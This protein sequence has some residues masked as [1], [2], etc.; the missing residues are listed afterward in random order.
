MKRSLMLTSGLRLIELGT[1]N[2]RA[3]VLNCPGFLSNRNISDIENNLIQAKTTWKHQNAYAKMVMAGCLNQAKR[4]I[5]M[6]D[7]VL[8]DG[9]KPEILIQKT[10][11]TISQ[12]LRSDDCRRFLSNA[13]STEE[14]TRTDRDNF[15]KR[16]VEAVEP[17][18]PI[19][20]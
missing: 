17:I 3:L 6:F 12:L 14:A 5:E 10:H 8:H 18:L 4:I 16:I 13:D 11:S 2:C 7:E 20:L 1:L 19:T 15:I 9:E